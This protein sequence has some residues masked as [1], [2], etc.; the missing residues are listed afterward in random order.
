VAIIARMQLKK[1]GCVSTWRIGEGWELPGVLRREGGCSIT[2]QMA[3]IRQRWDV[4][5][6]PLDKGDT[7]APKCV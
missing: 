5:F 4:R 7:V 6:D 2:R 3:P 1:R